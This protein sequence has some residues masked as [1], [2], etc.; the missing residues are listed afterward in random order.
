MLD[1]T[2]RAQLL[3]ALLTTT[4]PTEELTTTTENS[5][6]GLSLG[7]GSSFRERLVNALESGQPIPGVTLNNGLYF[8]NVVV[9][10]V[11]PDSVLFTDPETEQT[12]IVKID[13]ISSFGT[14][15]PTA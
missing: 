12:A 7:R 4:I 10:E 1:P 15:S 6:F 11:G 13:E 9:T 14:L 5:T 8:T 3:R 2:K